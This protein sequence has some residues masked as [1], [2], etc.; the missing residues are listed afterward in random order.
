[1]RTRIAGM[2]YTFTPKPGDFEGWGIFQP[3]NEK[4]AAFIEEPNLPLISKY[5]KILTNTI[6]PG[7]KAPG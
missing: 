1:M 7:A 6:K 3:I 5:L 2:V 4:Q